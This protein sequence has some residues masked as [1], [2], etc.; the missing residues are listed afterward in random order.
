MPAKKCGW[1]TRCA[2]S[3]P[4]SMISP[5]ATLI[6]IAFS[7]IRRSSRAPINPSVAVVSGADD[8]NIGDT[9]HLVEAVGRSDPVGRFV[10]RAATVDCVNFHPE[11]AHQPRRRDPDIAE[12]EDAA[13]AAAQHSV[14]TA[15]V[16][17]AALEVG[18]LDEQALCRSQ[19]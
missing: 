2:Y 4:S 14:G 9:Q 17:F 1:E 10:A 19:R 6:R 7:F 15:L 11:G 5:R 16:E 3:A 8:E 18:V 13:D 12:A